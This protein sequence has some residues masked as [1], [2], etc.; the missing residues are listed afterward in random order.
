MGDQRLERCRVVGQR[1]L[2]Q[3]VCGRR[4]QQALGEVHVG[5]GRR[6]DDVQ[7][8]RR[9]PTVI[10]GADDGVHVVVRC[11]AGAPHARAGRWG[12][13]DDACDIKCGVLGDDPKVHLTDDAEPDQDDGSHGGGI[14]VR[15]RTVVRA[16]VHH[17]R[18]RSQARRARATAGG[19][20]RPPRRGRPSRGRG[21]AVAGNATPVL[22]WQR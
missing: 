17:G 13:I 12:R 1:L 16:F 7:V 5:A 8:G 11:V 18:H 10:D 6:G 9:Q 3:D 15:S 2:G 19:G 20:A 21:Q 14:P 4:A 22:A